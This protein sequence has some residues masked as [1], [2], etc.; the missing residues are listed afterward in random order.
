[1]AGATERLRLVGEELLTGKAHPVVSALIETLPAPGSPFGA[2]ERQAWLGMM[3]TAFTLAYGPI[4]GKAMPKTANAPVPVPKA[5]VARKPRAPKPLGPTGPRFY[6]DTDNCAKRAGGEP[7]SP[8]EVVDE[9]VDL[10]GMNGDLATITW[11]DGMV[12]IPKGLQLNVTV[13]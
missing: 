5:K 8:H 9:L 4:E 3:E 1:M 2:A 7:V 13:G 12:G 6:V 11:A 10:R